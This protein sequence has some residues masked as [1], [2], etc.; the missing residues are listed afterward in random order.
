[1]P[2]YLCSLDSTQ[3][4]ACAMTGLISV[5]M[6]LEHVVRKSPSSW[7]TWQVWQACSEFAIPILTQEPILPTSPNRIYEQLGELRAY[8]TEFQPGPADS[9]RSVLVTAPRTKELLYRR[10]GPKWDEI[11]VILCFKKQFSL[12]RVLCKFK[13]DFPPL[14]PP[15]YLSTLDSTHTERKEDK[16]D[17]KNCYP[18]ASRKSDRPYK[19]GTVY[20]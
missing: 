2:G 6:A 15:S 10:K 9:Q 19:R 14:R 17:N 1:M 3:M 4:E 20:I 16:N 11:N 8:W 18:F 12:K 5:S 7:D 13:R